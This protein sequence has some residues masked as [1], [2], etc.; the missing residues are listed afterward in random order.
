LFE[1][2]DDDKA[3]QSSHAKTNREGCDGSDDE[4]SHHGSPPPIAKP[5]KI[6]VLKSKQTS[7]GL[8][9]TTV[10]N[11]KRSLTDTASSNNQLKKKPENKKKTQ[12]KQLRTLS[13]VC[14]QL[15]VELQIT[16]NLLAP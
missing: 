8:P 2:G 15:G 3:A 11:K 5:K 12:Q 16:V 4:S 6:K 1:A 10:T 14:W 9:S 13:K 7:P